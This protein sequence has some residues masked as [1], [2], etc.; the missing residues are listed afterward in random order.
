MTIP[1][2]PTETVMASTQLQV[3]PA[4]LRRLQ[5]E[6]K[7]QDVSGEGTVGKLHSQGPMKRP[8]NETEDQ[9]LPLPSASPAQHPHPITTPKGE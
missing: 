9:E 7:G 8:L 3:A 4:K 2:I 6:K 5:E 1:S